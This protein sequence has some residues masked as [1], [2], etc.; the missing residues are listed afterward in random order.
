MS[1]EDLKTVIENILN[2]NRVGEKRLNSKLVI[3]L[4]VVTG[5][6]VHIDEDHIKPLIEIKLSA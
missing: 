3:K 4:Q 5:N 1:V 2:T 6:S